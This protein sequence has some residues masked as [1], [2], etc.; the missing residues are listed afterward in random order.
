MVPVYHL[1]K[2]AARSGSVCSMLCSMA[3]RGDILEGSLEIKGDK[4]SEGISLGKVLN[5]L[6]HGVGTIRATHFVLKWSSTFGNRFLLG[7]PAKKGQTEAETHRQRQ[8]HRQG[9][10]GKGKGERAKGTGH[11]AQ[12]KGQRA[13]GKGHSAQ[14]T[15]AHGQGAKGKRR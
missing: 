7:Q 6:D 2:T 13:K 12:G 8:G 15:G 10:R 3:R 5:C 14:G 1:E 4:Y 11:R 9:Q